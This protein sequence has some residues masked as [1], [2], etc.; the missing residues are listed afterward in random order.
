VTRGLAALGALGLVVL[1]AGC[2]G[3]GSKTLATV[4][5]ERITQQQVDALVAR[6]RDEARNERQDFPDRGSEVY[7]ELQQQALAMLVYRV[8]VETAARRL[9]IA[10]TDEQARRS[11]GMTAPRHKD[12][13]EVVFEHAIGAVGIEE[14]KDE[15]GPLRL[16]DARLALTLAALERKLGRDGVQ[17]W[18]ERARRSVP[19]RYA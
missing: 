4:A 12:L 6:A 13:P 18:I 2:G 1:A 19:V 11:L 7:R 8:Q 10:V 3:T 16:A 9:G 17:P 5:G 15:E 14:G